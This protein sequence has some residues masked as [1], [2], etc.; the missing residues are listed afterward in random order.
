MRGI[1]F[2]ALEL[3]HYRPAIRTICIFGNYLRCRDAFQSALEIIG[4]KTTYTVRHTDLII[5]TPEGGFV[6]FATCGNRSDTHRLMGYR[7]KKLWVDD[8]THPA[9]A[10]TV[11]AHVER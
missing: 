4:P 11:R 7:V 2:N 6:K 1:V 3:L 10:E 8:T 9:L 5:E